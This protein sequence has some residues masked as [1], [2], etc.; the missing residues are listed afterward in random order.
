MSPVFPQNISLILITL[1][2]G[3]NLL[4][5]LNPILKFLPGSVPCAAIL[6]LTRK[7]MLMALVLPSMSFG[8]NFRIFLKRLH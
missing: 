8:G 5:V 2:F 4:K 7:F 3:Q 6:E 1:Y